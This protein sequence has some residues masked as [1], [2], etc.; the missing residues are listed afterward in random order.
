VPAEHLLY[1][2]DFIHRLEIVHEDVQIKLFRFSLEGIARDWYLSLP[3]TSISSLAYFHAAFHLFCKEIFSDDFLYPECCHEFNL[4][5][6]ELDIHEEYDA[7]ENTL[8]YD[9]EIGDPHYDN[10][11]EAFDIIPNASIVLGC[12]EDQIVPS[13]NLKNDEQIF[14]SACDRFESAA[15]L[16][17]NPQHPNLQTKEDCRNHEEHQEHYLPFEPFVSVFYIKAVDDE[18]DS[19]I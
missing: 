14:T 6:K 13:I 19:D 12:H 3:V 17:G 5:N 11:G 15:D 1:F 4:L 16:K 7:I 18:D 10:C 8:Q 2:H 9:R